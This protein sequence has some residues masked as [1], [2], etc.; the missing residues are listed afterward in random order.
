MNKVCSEE[1]DTGMALCGLARMEWHVSFGRSIFV[2][3]EGYFDSVLCLLVL[4]EFLVLLI[5]MF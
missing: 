1:N 3:F 4:S 5:Q 2:I